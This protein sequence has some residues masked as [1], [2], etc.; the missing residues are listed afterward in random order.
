[1]ATYNVEGVTE[2]LGLKSSETVRRWIRET[3]SQ[4]KLEA[5]KG[6]GRR[7]SVI[8]EESLLDFLDRNPQYSTDDVRAKLT[9]ASGESA[10]DTASVPEETR[11][12]L[13]GI[14]GGFQDFYKTAFDA[15]SGKN[16]VDGKA[17]GQIKTQIQETSDMLEE[18]TEKLSLFIF[19]TNQKIHDLEDDVRKAKSELKRI[20]DIKSEFKRI[21]SLAQQEENGEPND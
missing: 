8:S 18:Q 21:E 7:G 19:E 9:Q 2:L 1:M 15:L 5:T 14:L 12:V 10:Q 11:K 4:K 16:T 20:D 3:D 17:F 6:L 13:H